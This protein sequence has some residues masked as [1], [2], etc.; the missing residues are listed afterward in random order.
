M[1]DVERF[2]AIAVGARA[3]GHVCA[4]CGEIESPARRVA[5]SWRQKLSGLSVRA[6]RGALSS[7]KPPSMGRGPHGLPTALG[8]SSPGDLVVESHK[9]IC[10]RGPVISS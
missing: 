8:M 3:N 2:C 1:N 5:G 7:R 4:C 9:T 10:N 6:A